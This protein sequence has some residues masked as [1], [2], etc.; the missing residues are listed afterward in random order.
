MSSE[1]EN[2][3]LENSKS[4]KNTPLIIP[5]RRDRLRLRRTFPTKLTKSW[6]LE[7]RK[8]E[9]SK[10]RKNTPLIPQITQSKSH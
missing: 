6:E 10:S 8:M 7:N 1:L 2:R 5:T 3:K 9:N 4:R